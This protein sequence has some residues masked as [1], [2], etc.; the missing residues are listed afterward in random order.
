MTFNISQETWYVD[1]CDEDKQRGWWSSIDE[2]IYVI[3]CD[4]EIDIIICDYILF[5][6][7]I[8]VCYDMY[9]CYHSIYRWCLTD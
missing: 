1:W 7:N 4:G 3:D 2:V 9:V 6:I 8:V 5:M